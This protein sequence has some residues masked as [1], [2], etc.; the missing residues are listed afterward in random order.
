MRTLGFLSLCI[1][2]YVYKKKYSIFKIHILSGNV[3][4]YQMPAVYV[5]AYWRQFHCGARRF[6]CY[7]RLF[8]LSKNG[9]LEFHNGI[10]MSCM[11][12]END[13]DWIDNR[14]I[15]TIEVWKPCRSHK[16]F[17]CSTFINAAV[18]KHTQW[19]LTES[20]V[21]SWEIICSYMCTK[22]SF[23]R[24]SRLCN[25]FLRYSKWV[26]MLWTD[27][28]NV[29]SKLYLLWKSNALITVFSLSLTTR[30]SSCLSL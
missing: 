14:Q 3:W 1:W 20:W 6:S 12:T 23:D 28:I 10:V 17:T 26:V 29:P 4:R 7:C 15:W 16:E 11:V 25:W 27:F 9:F 18:A 22:V 30:T 2:S 5:F 21:T 24:V 13:L 8:Q 19:C